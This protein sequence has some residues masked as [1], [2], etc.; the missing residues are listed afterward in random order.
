MKSHKLFLYGWGCLV[1]FL[2]P[3][4]VQASSL[5]AVEEPPPSRLLQHQGVTNVALNGVAT[6]Q[7]NYA[8]DA[9]TGV[10][11]TADK[12]IDGVTTGN[13]HILVPGEDPAV[14]LVDLIFTKSFSC[15][16]IF[17][18]GGPHLGNTHFQEKVPSQWLATPRLVP[19]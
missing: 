15:L 14:V 3:H 12:A 5:G 9:N 1:A 17:F 18:Q 8:P 11:R 7:C 6:Q 4:F 13:D 10:V 2:S 19:P 16:V